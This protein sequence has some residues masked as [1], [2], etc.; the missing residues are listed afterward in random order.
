[1]S[2]LLVVAASIAVPDAFANPKG[3]GLVTSLGILIILPARRVCRRG[4]PRKAM[5]VL[6][7]TYWLLLGTVAVLAQK[8]TSMALPLLGILPAVAMVTGIRAA[9]VFGTLFVVLVA[10]L[11]FGREWH[12][13][14]PVLFAVRPGADAVLMVVALYTLLLPLPILNRALTS[15]GRRMLDFSQIS[16]DGHWESDAEH[17]YTEYWGRGLSREQMQRR[18]GCKPWEFEPSADPNARSQMADFRGLME[19]HQAISNFEYRHVEPDGCVNWFAISAIPVRGPQGQFLGFR[20]CITDINWRK[21]KEADLVEAR[22]AAESA[23]QAKSDFLANMSHEIRTP[24]N[25]IIGMSHLVMKTELTPRQRDYVGKIQSSCQ[26]LLSLINDILDFSKIEAD[27]LDVEHV[28][29]RVDGMLDNV[30]NLIGDKAAAKGLGLAFDIAEDVPEMLVGDPLRLG[31][32]FINYASNAVKFTEH[33]Q[34]QLALHVSERAGDSLLLRGEVTDTGIGLTPEQVAR[35]F[36]SFQ[37]AD[38]STTR[39]HGGTGLGLSIAKKL[40]EL[41]G[42]TVGVHSTPGEGSTFWF[43]ARLGIASSGRFDKCDALPLPSE[44]VTHVTDGAE[45]GSGTLRGA[46][47]LLVDDNDLNQQ[48]VA[49]MLGDAGFIVD[50]AVNGQ[51]ALD[52]VSGA[53]EPYDLVLMD[54]QMP[55]M[56]GVIAAQRIRQFRDAAQLP[57]VAMTANAMQ[58]DRK[59][60]LAAGMQEVVTKPID[61][62]ELW[63]ALR[64][65]IRPEAFAP[66]EHPAVPA[67]SSIDET[68]LPSGIE[69][70]DIALGLKRVLGKLPSYL[71]MLERYVSGQADTVTALMA[72][73]AAG[74][75]DTAIRLAHSTRGLSGT[76]GALA[77]QDCAGR[78]E[79]L[80]RDD[81][82]ADV[83]QQQLDVLRQCLEPLVEALGAHLQRI[84]APVAAAADSACSAS[85]DEAQL[86]EVTRRLRGLLSDMDSEALDCLEQHGVLLGAAYPQCFASLLEAA[87]RFDF[88]QAVARLDAAVADRSRAS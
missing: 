71:A 6:A 20:G 8:P 33:G 48:V 7:A 44:P 23:A 45:E 2:L 63:P 19:R 53:S 55:V 77:V 80:L 62:Q 54:M 47:L 17:R 5:L 58:Q 56:D 29:F 70:L 43:T 32:I 87:Q 39:K 31:Q 86:A 65:W 27:K 24:M 88:D 73:L 10:L 26:H 69:G 67:P 4:Q 38:T 60:C 41:M 64:A 18:I 15:S 34:I 22:V 42:G 37:Q 3:V 40:A 82:P 74:D 78:L 9:S 11:A 75:R 76:I 28:A 25:A 12:I 68:L 79:Q 30:A 36:E 66:A 21:R 84:G 81:A 13:G 46:R 61:P 14:L 57:I 16:A 72:A 49:E 52:K 1:V 85:V 35:L 51:M 50:I 59:R 83:A